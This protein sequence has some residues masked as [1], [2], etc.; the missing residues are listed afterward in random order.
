MSKII[1]IVLVALMVFITVQVLAGFGIFGLDAAAL[2]D[3]PAPD[4]TLTTLTGDSKSLSGYEG[5]VVLLTFWFPSCS[6]CRMELPRLETLWKEHKESGFEVLAIEA[7]GDNIGAEK[8][9]VKYGINFTV[10]KNGTAGSGAVDKL[11]LVDRYPTSFLID[12]KGVVRHHYIG[13]VPGMERKI[14]K[15]LKV[16]LSEQ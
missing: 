12:R 7:T 1:N 16:L 5:N 14:E 11:Y 6:A 13:F 9:V 8:F 15:D 4:F 2:I 3:A 10:L